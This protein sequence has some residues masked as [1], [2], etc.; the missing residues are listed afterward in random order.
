MRS[1]LR[2]TLTASTLVAASFL[3]ACGGD[4]GGSSGSGQAVSIE[5]FCQRIEALES[6]A[7]PDDIGAAVAAI[8]GLVDSAPTDEVRKA[9]ETLVPVLSRMSEIDENDPDAIGELMGLALDPEIMAA[10]A[11]LET[12]G[13]DECGFASE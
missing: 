4:D 6:A 9:L 1:S 12:F 13:T 11:V 3:A 10:S 5:E 8:Q 2:S 7:A